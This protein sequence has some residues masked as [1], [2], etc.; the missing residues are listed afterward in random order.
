M[1]MSAADQ[2]V[3]GLK[4]VAVA[5]EDQRHAAVGDRHHRLKPPEIAVGAPVLG[6][7]DAGA[8]E[9]AGMLFEL[10]FEPLEQGERVGRCAGEARDHRAVAQGAHLARVR[11]HHRVAERNL[12]VAGDHHL[13][14]L[15]DRKDGGA[16]PGRLVCLCHLPPEGRVPGGPGRAP[17]FLGIFVP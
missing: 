16:V 10:G 1:Q 17:A 9:L 4:H 7:L 2:T 11:F 5:G 6:E 14:A 12:P 13:A 15:A 3:L 8:R